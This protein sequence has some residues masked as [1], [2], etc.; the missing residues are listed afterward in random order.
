MSTFAYDIRP[1]GHMVRLADMPAAAPKAVEHAAPAREPDA[2]GAL[3]LP[4]RVERHPEL[5]A[6]ARALKIP[7]QVT[8]P[9]GPD[10]VR[11]ARVLS[12]PALD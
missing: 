12:Q 10:L 9:W 3:C 1:S 4:C 7:T 5:A 6:L 8:S 11:L 2:E